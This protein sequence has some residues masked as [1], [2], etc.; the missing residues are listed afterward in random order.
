MRNSFLINKFF[1]KNEDKITILSLIVLSY[2]SIISLFINTL[3]EIIIL[4]YKIDTVIIYIILLTFFLSGF[5]IILKRFLRNTP[6]I[7]FSIFLL[8]SFFITLLF[9]LNQIDFIL[10]NGFNFGLSFIFFLIG[11]SLKDFFKF[12]KFLG[13]IGTITLVSVFTQFFIFDSDFFLNSSY[14]QNFAYT[15]L[16]PSA[17]FWDKFLKRPSFLSLFF[18]I[19][20]SSF[21]ILLGSRGPL[22]SLVFFLGLSL[23]FNDKNFNKIPFL[24]LLLV[25]GLFF[26]D[27]LIISFESLA[28]SLN[29]SVRVLN[30]FR[31]DNFFQDIGRIKIIEISLRSLIESPFFGVGLFMDRVLIGKEFGSNFI[32]DFSG[33]YPHNI[34]IEILLNF[35]LLIGF[36]LIFSLLFSFIFLL[37]KYYKNSTISSLTLIF[38][39]TSFAPLIVSSS[40][41]ESTLFFFF[42]GFIFNLNKIHLE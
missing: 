25:F 10:S 34:F 26:Y 5:S 41:L 28:N 17:I 27:I 38:L 9:N 39:S 8:V 19:L 21:I 37:F 33:W 16:L 23:L 7:L 14:N 42:L 3:R 22:F 30:F 1:I 31:N 24:L 12:Y 6:A 36:F 11:L 15:L 13:I 32:S 2:G 18:F 40:Y 20:S 29:L 35:G 4:P